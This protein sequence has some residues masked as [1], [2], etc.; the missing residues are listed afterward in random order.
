MI[1]KKYLCRDL[2]AA[3]DAAKEIGEVLSDTPHKAALVTIYERGFSQN[4]IGSLIEALKDCA[5]P[6]PLIT[7][8][9]CTLIAEN[10]PEGTGIML[11]LLLTDEADL[12]VVSVPCMPGF[13][14]E[15]ASVLRARLDEHGSVKAVELFVSNMALNTTCFMK[16]AM[17]GHEDAVL[18]GT[19]TIRN[20]PQKLSTL[21][22]ETV[23]IE[24]VG[25]DQEQ[26]EFVIGNDILFDGFSA[27]IFAGEKLK[28]QA[29]YA[30]G[31][32]PVGR[33]LNVEFGERTTKG[34]TVI[35]KINGAPA[36]DIYREYLG[37]YPDSFLISNICEFPLVVEREGIN[38]CLI[39]IDCGKDGELYFMMTVEQGEGLRFTFA[40]HDEVLNSSL[41]SLKNLEKFGPET[42]F[43]IP[44]G[45]RINFLR[46]DAHMEWDGFGEVAPGFALVHG[47]CELYY[48]NKKGGILN[49]AHLAIGF[50]E[51]DEPA[52]TDWVE[53]P[54]T[55]E[56]RHGRVLSLSDR[57]S[58]F[59]ST[60]TVELLDM[61]KEARD[62]NNAKSA[63]LSHMS[64]EIRTPINAI[65]G[66]NQMI[67]QDSKE[68]E[69]LEYAGM[70]RSSGNNL[71][72][73]VNDILDLSKIEAG[74]MN[75]VPVEYETA[76]L[77]NDLYNVVRLRANDKG[78]AVKLDIDPEI[79]SVLKGD[80]TRI[81]QVIT[82]LLTNA[83][84]YTD[85]GS[86]TLMV[87]RIAAMDGSVVLRVSVKDTGIGIKPEDMKKLFE[88]YQRFDEERNRA[89]EGTGL[90]LS[91][92]RDLLKLMNSRLEVK[93]T[94]GE[95]SVFG[96]D[97]EQEVIKAGPVGD[98]TE[99]F[100]KS[101][102]RKYR[103]H[104][105]AEDARI[106]VVDDSAVN[107]TVV[108]N[109]LKKTKINI[110]TAKSGQEALAL[111]RKNAYDAIFLDHLMPGMDGHE[112]LK[113]MRE[114]DDNLSDK[115]P[116]IS[117]TANV[118]ANA[119][120]EYISAGYRD[121]LAKPISLKELED[122]L[123]YYL[124]PEKIRT[125]PLD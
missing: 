50:R 63:F 33:K 23:E 41:N 95:G 12:E 45:N 120:D 86:V 59:L 65:L 20:L 46:E 93:S 83:V 78:L 11:N 3:M 56:M 62:A 21:E 66:M 31:W 57:M 79:P 61:A 105:T 37:V 113:R 25:P 98:L 106:L 119:R 102:V 124:P 94:Y 90:G 114:L 13:E 34:E 123:F 17:E 8:I 43:L 15:A 53:H 40:S 117:L 9:S 101:A 19:S 36:V 22:D 88:E 122:M 54:T 64:H 115:A 27:V 67:L 81:K 52:R 104:F 44:C 77:I 112:T 26:N 70:I 91:I 55:Y 125:V 82:N 16:N 87:Q 48:H 29:E 110:D 51:K 58:V 4:E 89:V 28:V 68:P 60:I 109:L 49:S 99:K 18:F 118:S 30:L 38:I 1:Q 96:F 71:L 7:G 35:T 2:D 10:M 5:R 76:S 32:S 108:V 97:L 116:V 24:Q 121:Y 92:T 75:L 47:A 80:E 39:P 100:N 6:E 103:V 111:V 107:L 84:K 42:L 73:I 72:N 69:T 74:R 14:K 85:E